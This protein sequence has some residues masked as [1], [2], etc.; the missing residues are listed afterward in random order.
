M[1]LAFNSQQVGS[2]SRKP[3]VVPD[4]KMYRRS[5]EDFQQVIKAIHEHKI[6]E[7]RY[8]MMHATF[9][10]LL[11]VSA[12]TIVIPSRIFLV[13]TMNHSIFLQMFM[14]TI[15]R[16]MDRLRCWSTRHTCPGS[17]H[18]PDTTEYCSAPLQLRWRI[19][20]CWAS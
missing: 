3:H 9:D 8:K 20:L 6:Y 10:V 16:C 4:A 17:V 14:Y 7:N 2:N 5:L 15:R 18:F 12:H 1:P 11:K 13:V 19:R